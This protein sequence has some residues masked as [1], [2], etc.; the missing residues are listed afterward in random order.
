MI[1]RFHLSRMQK[2]GRARMASKAR[3]PR[4][5][6]M[7]E[8]LVLLGI[9]GLILGLLIPAVQA[10]R[11]VARRVQCVSHM[12][13]I[14]LAMNSYHSLHQ[15]YP[16]SQL[17]TGSN[18]TANCMSELSYL[19]PHLEMQP[20]FSS[21]NMS[22]ANSE[23]LKFPSL[24]NHT[25]RNKE[26]GLFTCPSDRAAFGLNSYRFNRGRFGMQTGPPFDGPFSILA[27]P[28]D[29]T[30]T[31]GLA[32]TAFVSE[33]LVGTSGPARILGNPGKM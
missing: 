23:S 12:R 8:L 29:A 5:F 6:T 26:I 1:D 25:A 10:A 17:L 4:A 9:I 2:S 18:W 33:R 31:D 21:I 15:M 14:G 27:L 7:I 20:L 19:L 16:S 32:N 24:E 28:R 13:Q 3:Y 30:V 11:E 22:F